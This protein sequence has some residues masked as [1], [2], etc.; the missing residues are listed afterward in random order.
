MQM[1]IQELETVAF[2]KLPIKIF[3][4]NNEGYGIIKQT[5]DT[6]LDSR[7]VGAD[8]ENGL[9]I[10]NFVKIANA[11]GIEATEMKSQKELNEKIRIVL[12]IDGPVLCDVKLDP[13][14][15]ITPKLTW[16]RPL[17]DLEPLL[18]R[19]ELAANM[20]I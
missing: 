12:N 5:Q 14:Q 16:G 10:P 17:E 8:P 3:L 6:W 1:N 9:G 19:E 13:N 20:K 4:I 18:P 15:K 2:Y 11:Y 7:Y